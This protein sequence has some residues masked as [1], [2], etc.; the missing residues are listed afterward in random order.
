MPCDAD[1]ESESTSHGNTPCRCAERA[2]V[3]EGSYQTCKYC[4]C[5]DERDEQCDCDAC[6][7]YSENYQ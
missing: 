1:C 5:G 7:C 4:G 6:D 2:G 3:P